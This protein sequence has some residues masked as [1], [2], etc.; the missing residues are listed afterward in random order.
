MGRCIEIKEYSGF[1]RGTSRP[2]LFAPMAV[3]S[4]PP[5]VRVVVDSVA[6][7]VTK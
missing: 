1:D 3:K 7:W 4:K 5:P 6:F 2:G